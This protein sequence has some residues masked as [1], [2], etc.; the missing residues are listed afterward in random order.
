MGKRGLLERNKDHSDYYFSRLVL[1]RIGSL[2]RDFYASSDQVVY[3]YADVSGYSPFFT[4]IGVGLFKGSVDGKQLAFKHALNAQ[5]SDHEKREQKMKKDR[6]ADGKKVQDLKISLALSKE[7]CEILQNRSKTLQKER[8]DLELSIA[9]KEK[10]LDIQKSEHTKRM[11]EM[12]KEHENL[13]SADQKKIQELQMSL[14]RSLQDFESLQN[15][16]K[17]LEKDQ[18]EFIQQLAEKE[19]SQNEEHTKQAKEMNKEIEKQTKAVK[20]LAERMCLQKRAHKEERRED[21]KKV[22]ELQESLDRCIKEYEAL[23][24]QTKKLQS[25]REDLELSIAKREQGLLIEKEEHKNQI[26]KITSRIEK[27]VKF[28]KEEMSRLKERKKSIESTRDSEKKIVHKLLNAA[29]Y[30]LNEYEEKLKEYRE[31]IQSVNKEV[32]ELSHEL[33]TTRAIQN[34]SKDTLS[35]ERVKVENL[36]SQVK[37]LK[38]ENVTMKKE[39]EKNE[40]ALNESFSEIQMLSKKNNVLKSKLSRIKN[41]VGGT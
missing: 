38:E 19:Q 11:Q 17:K 8:D 33:K 1:K 15:K 28:A 39:L 23:Q 18:N 7:E 25:E 14:A 30:S 22:Q 31:K 4:R 36:S 10:L 41:V 40:S 27:K 20:D 32:A 34:S 35:T 16:T 26:K 12:K 13:R 6:E 37:T 3:K 2:I 21:L 24:N 5:R 29:K 9:E